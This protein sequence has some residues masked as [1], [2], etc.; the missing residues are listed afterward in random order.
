M[1]HGDTPSPRRVL[2]TGGSGF[3]GS[4]LVEALG[5]R[6]D[7]SV[8]NYDVAPPPEPVDGTEWVEGDVLDIDRLEEAFSEHRPTHVVHMAARVDVDGRTLDDYAVNTKGTQNVVSVSAGTP[9]V[10]RLVFASTQF[11]C[12]PGRMPEADDDYDPHTVYGHSKVFGEKVLRAADVHFV[13]TIVRPTTIWG[14]RDLRYRR[15]FYSVMAR[16]WYLHPGRGACYRSYGYVGNVVDQIGHVLDAP[17]E[18]VDGRTFYVGDAMIDLVRFADEFSRQLHGRPTRRVPAGL[19]RIVA[20]FGDAASRLGVRFPL[21]S[22]RFRSMTEDYPVPIES[23]LAEVGGSPCSL[24]EGVR[25]T[26]DWLRR[27]DEIQALAAK[28]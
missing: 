5:R 20:L 13:W 8:F 7:G 6:R 9:T 18:R 10:Q 17:A 25:R 21:N 28:D 15:Q 26:L 12:R 14:P 22:Q 23:S 4:H 11:V 3:I 27:S 19:L 16:G 2:V 24:E 1:T